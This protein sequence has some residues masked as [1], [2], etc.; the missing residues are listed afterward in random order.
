[1]SYKS[2]QKWRLAACPHEVKGANITSTN[3]TV[4]NIDATNLQVAHIYGTDYLQ[5]TQDID[6][7]SGIPYSP[8]AYAGLTISA[9]A[10]TY[11]GG[12]YLPPV[13]DSSGQTVEQYIQPLTF[14]NSSDGYNQ[15]HGSLA[16]ARQMI[17]EDPSSPS[18]ISAFGLFG[19]PGENLILTV[20]DI[21]GGIY[22]FFK[23]DNDGALATGK[24]GI[25]VD[26]SNRVFM[27]VNGDQLS[28]GGLNYLV[29]GNPRAQLYVNGD[30][31]VDGSGVQIEKYLVDDIF[32]GSSAA[33]MGVTDGSFDQPNM[34]NDISLTVPNLEV[35]LETQEKLTNKGG[36]LMVA[37]NTSLYSNLG[38]S[39][40]ATFGSGNTL[41]NSGH[42][43]NGI[44]TLQL[45]TPM[46][47]G[48]SNSYVG[49]DSKISEYGDQ[50]SVSALSHAVQDGGG[51]TL[52]LQQSTADASPPQFMFYK[53]RQ[54]AATISG[55]VLGQIQFRGTYDD[56]NGTAKQFS[57]ARIYSNQVD[58][59]GNNLILT[60]CGPIDQPNKVNKIE[61]TYDGITFEG[62]N[63]KANVRIDQNGNTITRSGFTQ[64]GTS[65]AAPYADLQPPNIPPYDTTVHEGG[66]VYAVDNIYVSS[67][68]VSHDNGN[69]YTYESSNNIYVR[70]DIL[71]QN[72]TLTMAGSDAS[73]AGGHPLGT[74]ANQIYMGDP[75]SNYPEARIGNEVTDTS[76]GKLLLEVL[77]GNSNI[78]VSMDRIEYGQVSTNN[79]ASLAVITPWNATESQYNSLID[80]NDWSIP[81]TG[82]VKSKNFWKEYDPITATLN[83]GANPDISSIYVPE[84]VRCSTLACSSLNVPDHFVTICV[85]VTDIVWPWYYFGFIGETVTHLDCVTYDVTNT[86]SAPITD[87]SSNIFVHGHASML[88]STDSPSLTDG[89]LAVFPQDGGS[90]AMS[91]MSHRLQSSDAETATIYFGDAQGTTSSTMTYTNVGAIQG[92]IEANQTVGNMRFYGSDASG[93]LVNFMSY[94]GGTPNEL[95][96]S[97]G[98]VSFTLGTG[99]V[100]TKSTYTVETDPS[101]SLV[102]LSFVLTYVSSNSTNWSVTNNGTTLEPKS[103][104]IT[105]VEAPS[106]NTSSDAAKKENIQTISGALETISKLRGV[107]Y[108]LKSDETKKTHHGVIAQEL[109]QVFPDMVA[110]E[111]GSKSVAYMEIIGVLIEAVKDL[112]KRVEELEN[113]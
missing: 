73:G 79:G 43:I 88:Y 45:F 89:G 96:I 31:V 77:T 40:G 102:D 46:V 13:E 24:S 75:S 69:T 59:S 86:T 29:K 72:G 39:G 82:Y 74:L 11:K 12:Q 90:A 58:T 93:D 97:A 27:G 87:F 32:V 33:I 50:Y 83:N 34:V 55:D 51:G 63:Q 25:Y 104:S 41:D 66:N 60:G 108:N 35:E 5:S 52:T 54:G 30:I 78:G 1:M 7:A 95:D 81:T 38:V 14:W 44:E 37:N 21:S 68:P 92:E 91:V 76:G 26:A 42:W 8:I 16:Y 19:A 10:V 17:R 71:T 3:A 94:I 6:D 103:Q 111:E 47:P 98:D 20:G 53:D 23:G 84:T 56:S 61:L 112:R 105:T 110:G 99:G 100:I 70:G 57:T 28:P 101:D 9:E 106:F 15:V 36:Y 2:T 49:L 109:E 62:Y 65:T 64:D 22:N 48:A 85:E 107:T 18:N 4:R 113:K 67:R 80:Q